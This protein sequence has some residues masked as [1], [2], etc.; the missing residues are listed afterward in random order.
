PLGGDA[1]QDAAPAHADLPPLPHHQH[2]RARQVLHARRQ[3]LG[4]GRARLSAQPSLTKPTDERYRAA[5]TRASKFSTSHASFCATAT[6]HTARVPPA[7]SEHSAS[8]R[9]GSV[10][11]GVA[12]P[13]SRGTC[14][15]G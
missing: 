14:A 12:G 15:I 3:R 8:L 2:R 6:A 11:H 10:T 13:P 5:S 9:S 1:R 4:P 7:P